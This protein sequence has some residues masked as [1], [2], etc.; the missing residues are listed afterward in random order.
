MSVVLYAAS[1]HDIGLDEVL[2]HAA[3]GSTALLATPRTH[4]IAL[5]DASGD[6][7]TRK[8]SVR[9]QDVFEAR[10]FDERAELRWVN[11]ADGRGTAV[12]LTEDAATLPAAFVDRLPAVEAID[13]RAGAYLLWGRSAGSVNGWTTLSTERIGTIDIPAQ[14]PAEQH[15]QVLVQEYIAQDPNHGNAYI[16]EE[17]LLR[18]DLA[19]PETSTS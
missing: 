11:I 17:R 5:V 16:A 10:F 12:F 6:V 1:W 15:A 7:K 9:L 14:I 4:H 2:R 13:T 18:F 8:G 3:P 19:A